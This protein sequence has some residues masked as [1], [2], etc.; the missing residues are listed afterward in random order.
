MT[1][2]RHSTRRTA[3]TAGP[4]PVLLGEVRTALLRHSRAVGV[5]TVEELLELAPA[6]TVR[7]TSRPL[8]R[9]VSTDV[10]EGVHC[11]LPS[12]SGRRVEG[13]G[14]IVSRAVV[15]GGRIAQASSRALVLP[16]T[17]PRRQNWSAYLA[18]Q[19]IIEALGPGGGDDLAAGFLAPHRPDVLDLGAVAN[20]LLDRV[21][22]SLLLDG[23]SPLRTTRTRLRFVVAAAG[24]GGGPSTPAP[25][26]FSVDVD[27]VRTLLLRADLHGTGRELD[28][29]ETDLATQVQKG[30]DLAEFDGG[31][32]AELMT[33]CE[34]VAVHD[35]L[36][37]VLQRLVDNLDEAPAR[38]GRIERI[39]PAI[40][41]L[42]HLWMPGA[43]A[44]PELSWV[45]SAL[46]GR[47]GFSRQ[48]ASIVARIR[49]ELD[50]SILRALTADG[51]QARRAGPAEEL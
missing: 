37:T 1:A 44:E 10:V 32:A 25:P 33:L 16:A 38:N 2:P 22:T 40:E 34:D 42:L 12:G 18:R 47:P 7:L 50:L 5:E 21:Q 4:W 28:G 27:G 15:T 6:A 3:P 20:R 9:G 13:V 46:E 48:W 19:G 31:G 11:R 23:A 24:S 39:G 49:N 41:Q 17:A 8:A 43:H 29:A 51:G 26:R 35:W 45:W 36:L 30:L 14:T